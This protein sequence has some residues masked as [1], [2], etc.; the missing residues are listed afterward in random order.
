MCVQN[1]R[2]G[3]ERRFRRAKELL[4]AGRPEDQSNVLLSKLGAADRIIS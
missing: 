3:E 4:K 2:I 1:G